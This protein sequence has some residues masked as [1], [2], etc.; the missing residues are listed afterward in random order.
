ML[1]NNVYLLS[2]G[3]WR[4]LH[5][6]IICQIGYT[7]KAAIWAVQ[8]EVAVLELDPEDIPEHHT[9]PRAVTRSLIIRNIQEP[10]LQLLTRKPGKINS[11]EF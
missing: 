10:L 5:K 7:V 2:R 6:W 8:K 9:A 11:D 3:T 4:E 1:S